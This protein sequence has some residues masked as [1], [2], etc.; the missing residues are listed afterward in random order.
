[1]KRRATA[2][3]VPAGV[4]AKS[5]AKSAAAPAAPKDDEGT[6]ATKLQ[7]VQRRRQS[8]LDVAT[9][10]AMQVNLAMELAMERKEVGVKRFIAKVR[11]DRMRR[12]CARWWSSLSLSW[13]VVVVVVVCARRV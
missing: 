11:T 4:G 7:A 12:L 6:A 5:G 8:E 3:A 2:V 10:R 1:M 13:R 9:R